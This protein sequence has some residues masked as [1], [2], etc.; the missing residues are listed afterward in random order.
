MPAS[1]ASTLSKHLDYWDYWK[2]FVDDPSLTELSEPN[3]VTKLADFLAFTDGGGGRKKTKK[4]SSCSGLISGLV[5]IASK[6]EC[7]NRVTALD[8]PLIT[9][10]RQTPETI[11]GGKEALP[12]PMAVVVAFE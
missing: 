11:A 2:S 12:L 4:K 8:T 7:N 6:A 1:A 10:F 5:F 9:S 3:R